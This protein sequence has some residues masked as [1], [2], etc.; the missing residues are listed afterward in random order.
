[1]DIKTIYWDLG[2]VCVTNNLETAL[3]AHGA[4]Y[5]AQQKAAWAQH[6]LGKTTTE[7]FLK[8][9]LRGTALETK[10]EQLAETMRQYIRIQPNG[11][12]PIVM[13]LNDVGEYK[14]GVI[15][16]HSKEWGKYMREVLGIHRHF[17]QAMFII[18]ADVG[19]DKTGA[20]IFK[21]ALQKAG[22]KPDETL[23][24]DDQ[25]NNVLM[26]RKAGLHAEL[27]KDRDNAAE[28]LQSK[29]GIKVYQNGGR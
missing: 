15:S 7:E 6:R 23:F 2:G 11:A 3:I 16:N 21:L 27:F 4:S 8:Q 10:A 12:L 29:Y 1:M 9:A 19:L 26:A 14:Q 22:S 24:W 13:R 20:G 28:I 17:D 18:S 25:E 5:D